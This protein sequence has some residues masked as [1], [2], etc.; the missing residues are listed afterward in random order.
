[1]LRLARKISPEDKS[2]SEHL[3]SMALA[4]ANRQYET[5]LSLGS[6]KSEDVFTSPAERFTMHVLLA[7]SFAATQNIKASD[8]Y[9][10]AC[11]LLDSAENAALLAAIWSEC[12]RMLRDMGDWMRSKVAFEEA[13]NATRDIG[14]LFVL[15]TDI[16]E[17]MME[18]G[19]YEAALA[20]I[21]VGELESLRDL[22]AR[23]H[24]AFRRSR[25]KALC[26][27]ARGR[28]D[29]ADPIIRSITSAPDLPLQEAQFVELQG[30]LAAARYDV[31]AAASLLE[32]ACQSYLEARFETE[33]NEARLKWLRVAKD[34]IGDWRLAGFLLHGFNDQARSFS[35]LAPLVALEAAH[36]S[37]LSGK[38]DLLFLD[39]E[40]ATIA[41]EAEPEKHVDAYLSRLRAV[42][43]QNVRYPLLKIFAALPVG[44]K[45]PVLNN[46]PLEIVPPPDADD[47][48]YFPKALG[49]IDLLG[50]IEQN[51]GRRRL[52]AALNR[53]RP[54]LLPTLLDVV[55]R[56]EADL[57]PVETVRQCL[58]EAGKSG[59]G[60]A[61]AVKY[62]RIALDRSEPQVAAEVSRMLPEVP[63]ELA[64]TYI[65]AIHNL[66]TARLPDLNARTRQRARDRA[67]EILRRLGQDGVLQDELL[68]LPVDRLTEIPSRRATVALQE[69]SLDWPLHSSRERVPYQLA[70]RLAYSADACIADLKRALAE[71]KLPPKGEVELAIDRAPISMVPWEWAFRDYDVCYRSSA[72]LPA[73][74]SE[75]GA[76]QRL[77]APCVL[78]LRPPI[79]SQ[80]SMGRG[81][82]LQ[83]RK[84]LTKIYAD[85]GVQ[86]IEPRELYEEE[87][88]QIM[89]EFDPEVVHIR[90]AVVERTRGIQL[91]LPVKKAV[92]GTEYLAA[93]FKR[94]SNPIVI[95][96]PPRPMD[97]VET[98]LQ[99]LLR[100]SFAADL[101]A[102]GR[103]R[104]VL[105][106][107]L[108]PSWES[109]SVAAQLARKLSSSPCL[110]ELLEVF[111]R[112]IDADRFA[113]DGAALF[114]ADPNEIVL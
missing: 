54:S 97:E 96:D 43:P 9:S 41:R 11:R 7:R 52:R 93:V 59:F 20:A 42:C 57:P 61:A 40:F 39:H 60:F 110:H 28:P 79:S 12:A 19:N 71:W 44:R 98:A 105:A 34:Q 48:D 50:F 29:R 58:V 1:M 80:E 69:V 36:F 72:R 62:M 26:E 56:L 5:A 15:N 37:F 100:N 88:E 85:E 25:I 101:V 75:I 64:G 63:E 17:L 6:E 23:P 78:I 107:G 99:L 45:S 104:A 111:R 8:H 53:N 112:N 83:S 33:A 32:R 74:R 103:V 27:I 77:R 84:P 86:A 91:D 21:S 92:P 109:E 76:R 31:R 114:A 4:V 55:G 95:L 46:N 10:R 38:R 65:E 66:N 82:D 2:S 14:D 68:A 16:A 94:G 30:E 24:E 90:A 81:F 108:L 47:P 89:D 18:G 35:R 49:A 13:R 113:R 102:T 3:V 106:A 87:V 22:A 67:V 73:P 51:S 70:R